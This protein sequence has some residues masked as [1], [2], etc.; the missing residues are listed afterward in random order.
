MSKIH[1]FL[2]NISFVA[3]FV[4]LFAFVAFGQSLQSD[5]ENSFIK[6]DLVRLDNQAARRS[7]EN[8]QIISFRAAGK[9]FELALTPR[10]LR[11]ARYKAEDTGI[12]GAHQI[13]KSAVT[14]FK[15][16][17]AGEADSEVRLTIDGEKIEGFFDSNGERFFIEPALKYS[18]VAAADDSV[19]YRADDL[20][21]AREIF[22]DMA[23]RIERGK[24]MVAPNVSAASPQALRVIEIATEADFQ[25]LALFGNSPT[26]ANDEIVSVL[27]VIEGTYEREL[28]LT[29]SVVFQHTWT[30]PDPFTG[31]D[32]P[33][34]LA[35]F[36]D[37]WNANFPAAQIPRDTAHLFSGKSFTLGGGHA[38]IGV[39]CSNPAFAYGLSGYV[40]FVEGRY[41]ITAHEIGHNLGAN[42]NDTAECQNTIMNTSLSGN[43]PMTFCAAS[44]AEITNFV[45]ASG[46]CMSNLSNTR[47]DFDGDARADLSIFRPLLGE[48]WYLRS[49]DGQNRAFRFGNSNDRL[50]PAD[51]TGDGK[52][53]VAIFR[54]ASGEWFVLRSENQSFYAF[55]FGLSTDVPAPGDF[56]GDGKA[57]P[58]VFRP[59]TTTWFIMR[60]TGGTTIQQF[61][62]NGDVPVV[63]DYDN[64]DR[65]DIAVFRPSNGQWWL[66]RSRAGLV[67]YQFGNSS[68]KPVPGDYTGDGAADAAIF[69][70]ATGEW[71]VLRSENNSF[72][73]FP[74]GTGGDIPAPA[75]FDGDG[76][77]DAAVFR[78]TTSTWYVQRTS[79]TTLI[80]NFG[81][82]GDRPVPSAFIP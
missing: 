80:Q 63:A 39:I 5:L 2:Q 75:D 35:S 29:F 8:G 24:Q 79:S 54:P 27:N 44:R 41:L 30:T 59:S 62:A 58:A 50:V 36:K 13:E 16:K 82:I 10:D 33:S 37:Y 42:H 48:W 74:F 61:G 19:V 43:T 1:S 69:R 68:D 26:R 47:F 73:S 46:T 21:K 6:Y 55:A 76:R 52:T 7:A 23:E 38:Y 77:F 3:V 12:M 22:C 28:G 45:N 9:T 14:T 25:Y 67:A 78:P 15:G 72:F 20:L 70:P 4:L 40:D 60:S 53:D 34:L 65:D 56:D 17:I 71:F 51:Y 66:L 32:R 31:T 18:Q 11:A 57:D 64:D 81:I 49:S